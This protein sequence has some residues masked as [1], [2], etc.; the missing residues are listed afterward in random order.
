MERQTEEKWVKNQEGLPNI[1]YLS[2]QRLAI[3]H[4]YS[5][6]LLNGG[7]CRSFD[8]A[9]IL[10]QTQEDRSHPRTSTS[11]REW[12]EIPIGGVVKSLSIVCWLAWGNI[13]CI[14]DIEIT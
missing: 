14:V 12:F 1:H 2:F 10:A 7:K 5:F 4:L 8:P 6:N 3:F 9:Q 13:Q 11:G